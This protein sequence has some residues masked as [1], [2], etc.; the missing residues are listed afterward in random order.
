M[1]L[2]FNPSEGSAPVKMSIIPEGKAEIYMARWVKNFYSFEVSV[3]FFFV[4]Y[5]E[6]PLDRFLQLGQVGLFCWK[7]GFILG[8]EGSEVR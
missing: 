3:D 4:K 1:V 7:G 5:F 2:F 6:Q 8:Y